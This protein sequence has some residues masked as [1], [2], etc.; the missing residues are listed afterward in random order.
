MKRV[1][2]I[3][4]HFPP[5]A[6]GGS[7]RSLKFVKYLPEFGWLPTVL[8]TNTRNYG[9]YDVSLLDE[10]PKVVRIIRA[11]ELDP[12]YV[13]VLMSKLGLGKLYDIIEQN[14][15]SPDN[16][17]GWLPIAF[18]KGKRELKAKKYDLVFSTSPTV[19]AHILG[20]SLSR[21]LNIPWVC[22]FRDLWT[23]QPHYSFNDTR[24]GKKESTI[25]RNLVMN[26]DKLVVVTQT[27]KKEFLRNYSSLQP[28][29]IEV[30]Y[31]GFDQLSPIGY[32]ATNKLTI[33]YSG[34][35]YGQYYPVQLYKALYGLL[36]TNP[37]MTFHFL[38]IGNAEKRIISELAKYS[39]LNTEFIPF[40]SRRDLRKT[41]KQADALLIF[42]LGK[43]SSVP[44]KV[45]E[46][47]SYQK[48]ILAIVPK[49]ELREIVAITGMGYCAD[50]E[51]IKGIQTIL[52]NLYSDWIQKKLPKP[53]NLGALT[54]FQRINQAQNLSK[55]FEQIT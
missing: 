25:E 29:K 1:L 20:H 3:A 27:F 38:F 32:A 41:L 45:F 7:F 28:N 54:K 8:T 16:K 40:Q 46:Y 48:P 22:E 30:I 44:S 43:Y 42:Q 49:D 18:L 17:I 26:A 55:L 53:Q 6:G 24:R 52:K 51:D 21:Q 34:S 37:E 14:W 39:S 2:F 33:A 23:L 5:L 11:A 4:Y 31:N 50:P 19:C 35:M 10:I 12:F 9:A 36:K 13:H 47:L 15:I